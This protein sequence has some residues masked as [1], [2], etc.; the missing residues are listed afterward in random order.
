MRTAL[1]LLLSVLAPWV[2]GAQTSSYVNPLD[3]KTYEVTS[4]DHRLEGGVAKGGVMLSGV[5]LLSTQQAFDKNVDA[6]LLADFIEATKANVAFVAGEPDKPFSILL[7]T[8]LSPSGTPKFAMASKGDAPKGTLEK[9]FRSLDTLPDLRTKIDALKYQLEFTIQKGGG[10]G[11]EV[12]RR[13][14]D[15]KKAD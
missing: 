7:E 4:T 6:A 3:G 10:T 11:E 13:G 9:V 14:R 12:A 2:A 1:S 8:T 5:R 15:V